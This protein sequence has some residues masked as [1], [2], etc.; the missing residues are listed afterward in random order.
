VARLGADGALADPVR[1]E[2]ARDQTVYAMKIDGR[3]HALVAGSYRG[4]LAIGGAT[5]LEDKPVL[6]DSG[7][8]VSLDPAGKPAW[9]HRLPGLALSF[10]GSVAVDASNAVWIAG[11]VGGPTK[12]EVYVERLDENGKSTFV[13]SPRDGHGSRATAVAVDSKGNA[14]ILGHYHLA[15]SLGE[16][17]LFPV[18]PDQGFIVK[19]D[20]AGSV[21][22]SVPLGEWA[23]AQHVAV[24]AQDRVWVTGRIHA[25]TRWAGRMLDVR[26]GTGVLWALDAGGQ[27]R[28]EK[29]FTGW[30]LSPRADLGVALYWKYRQ[31]FEGLWENGVLLGLDPAGNPQLVSTF[32]GDFAL[33]GRRFTTKQARDVVLFKLDRNDGKVLYARQIGGTE[34]QLAH[35]L[36]V[37]GAGKVYVGGAHVDKPHAWMMSAEP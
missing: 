2:G 14:V 17:P 18:G 28:F 26:D 36:A 3:G 15:L 31:W 25:S 10:A 29:Q 24:D 4:V 32:R 16:K 7:F 19:I 11:G 1:I 5:V 37:D 35:A 22:W 9:A 23:V 21:L 13:W 6:N 27:P 33:E 12:W 20:R 8:V 34:G 30:S